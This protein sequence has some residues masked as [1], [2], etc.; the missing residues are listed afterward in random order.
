LRVVLLLGWL[1]LSIPKFSL[2]NE[3]EQCTTLSELLDAS[4]TIAWFGFLSCR[5]RVI[6]INT[7]LKQASSGSHSR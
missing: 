5:A 1:A 4:D 3:S 2:K 7:T 6:P